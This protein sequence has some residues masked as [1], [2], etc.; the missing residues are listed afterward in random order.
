MKKL[1]AMWLVVMSLFFVPT[2][3]AAIQTYTGTDDY[4]VGE[5]ETQEDAQN[6]SKLRALRNAQE[7]AGLYIRSRSRSKDLE[8]VEDEIVT[9]TEGIVKIVGAPQYRKEILSDGKSI[10]IHTTVT[11]QIDTDDVDRRLEE[12]IRQHKPAPTT[13]IDRPQPIETPAPPVEEQP[14]PVETVIDDKAMANELLSL[15]NAER[16]KAGKKPFVVNEVLTYAAK[17]RAKELSQ[18]QSSTRPNG[19]EWT[20]AVPM[21]YKTDCWQDGFWGMNSPQQIVDWYMNQKSQRKRILGS[22]YNKIGIAHFYKADS[23][24]KHYWCILTSSG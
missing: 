23:E 24:H 1:L 4:T 16:V 18:N 15:L 8:L 21:P 10:L 9:L 20:T 2:V 3:E 11:V 22:R 19:T 12:I 14:A 5:R 13:P 7:Q 17:V 6:N